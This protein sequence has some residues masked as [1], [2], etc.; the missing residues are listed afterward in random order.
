MPAVG[1]YCYTTQVSLSKQ[2]IAD[3]NFHCFNHH[4]TGLTRS[5]RAQQKKPTQHWATMAT[6]IGRLIQISRKPV[7][8]PIHES[9]YLNP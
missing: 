3:G 1:T 5:V 9:N 6:C 8:I 4:Q 7:E 2:S